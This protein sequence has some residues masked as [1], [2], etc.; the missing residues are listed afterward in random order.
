MTAHSRELG[1]IKW[2]VRSLV[3]EL[4]SAGFKVWRYKIEDTVMDSR[5]SD[6]LELLD[7]KRV[8]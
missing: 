4:L 7:D 3:K 8:V 1:N 6:E 2:K 5:T